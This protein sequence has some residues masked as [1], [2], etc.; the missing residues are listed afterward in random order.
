MLFYVRL[1]ENFEEYIRTENP[2]LYRYV[3][4]VK[5]SFD[6]DG[7][8][9]VL[10]VNPSKVTIRR[11]NHIEQ[12]ETTLFMLPDKKNNFQW[13]PYEFFSFLETFSK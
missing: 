7:I 2:E 10:M 9:P 5:E 3:H 6:P 4:M 1:K 12:T 13:V 8:Y 11:D